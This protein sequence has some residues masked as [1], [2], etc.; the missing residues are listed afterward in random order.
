MRQLNFEKKASGG[1]GG[2]YFLPWEDFEWCHKMGCAQQVSLRQQHDRWLPVTTEP[3]K[4]QSKWGHY[5]H[6]LL[7]EICVQKTENTASHVQQGI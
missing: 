5:K 2:G 4:K 3:S 6:Y 1:G 7:T